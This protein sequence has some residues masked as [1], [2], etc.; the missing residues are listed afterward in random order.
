MRSTLPV[1]SPLPKRQPST[2][3]A[4][5]SWPSSAAATAQPRS[6]WGWRDTMTLSLG[7]VRWKIST[8]SAKVF[9]VHI[10]TVAGRLRMIGTSMVGSHASLTASHSAMAYE[11]S[12]SEKASGL[13]IRF[14]VVSGWMS[15]VIDLVYCTQST[16]ISKT[17]CCDKPNIVDWKLSLDAI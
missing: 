15:F 4:P 2:L 8:W 12:V 14:H 5:A 9:G 17:S 7:K 13:N 6:L 10:S 1:R 16:A 11:V 3:V